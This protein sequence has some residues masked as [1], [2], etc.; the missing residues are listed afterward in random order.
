MGAAADAKKRAAA[1]KALHNKLNVT[2]NKHLGILKK[3]KDAKSG[4]AAYAAGAKELRG[5]VK[6]ASQVNVKY[7]EFLIR[8][9]A[10]QIKIMLAGW[11]KKDAATWAANFKKI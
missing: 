5:L 10:N 2:Y 9:L 11:A 3:T 1:E 4:N 6:K 8:N 7:A